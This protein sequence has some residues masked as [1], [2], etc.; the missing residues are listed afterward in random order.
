MALFRLQQG[1]FLTVT[2]MILNNNNGASLGARCVSLAFNE[3]SKTLTQIYIERNLHLLLG[4]GEQSRPFR[5][6]VVTTVVY[7]AIV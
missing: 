3:N 5:S 6:L 2:I 1:I 7:S 4:I